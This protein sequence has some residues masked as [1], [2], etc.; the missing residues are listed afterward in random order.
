MGIEILNERDH[1]GGFDPGGWI[2][3][4]VDDAGEALSN[5]WDAF[6]DLP[7]FKQLGEGAK[8]LFKGPLRDFANSDLGKT[9]LRAATTVVAGPAGVLVGPWAM[10]MAHTLPGLAK[11]DS[12]IAALVEENLYRMTEAVKILTAGQV[13]IPETQLKFLH[14]LPN[15]FKTAVKELENR[16]RSSFPDVDLGEAAERLAS[17]AGLSL[18]DSARDLARELGLRED[19]A[20]QAMELISKQKLLTHEEY[21]LATG[22]NLVKPLVSAKHGVISSFGKPLPKTPVAKAVKG[23]TLVSKAVMNPTLAQATAKSPAAKALQGATL[24]SKVA[25]SG[26]VTILP[27][28]AKRAPDIMA[29]VVKPIA[30]AKP[31]ADLAQGA[32]SFTTKPESF[33]TLRQAV[34]AEPQPS[35]WEEHKIKLLVGGGAV[36]LVGLYFWW[37]K[38]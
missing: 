11:G 28:V 1:T 37:A 15:Q 5:V 7:G 13:Q 20:V 35:F 9:V 8:A 29:S 18:E 2:S 4:R 14:E 32:E 3:D 33:S 21:D 30:R 10:M 36:A 25:P 6:D 12:F 23:A 27:S 22:R 38:R 31:L 17:E 26:S 24:V 19:M 34:T 16:I